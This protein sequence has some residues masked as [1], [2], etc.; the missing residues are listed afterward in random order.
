M[1]TERLAVCSD[2]MSGAHAGPAHK[3]QGIQSVWEAIVMLKTANEELSVQ[4]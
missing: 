2:W 1:I 3:I 4:S